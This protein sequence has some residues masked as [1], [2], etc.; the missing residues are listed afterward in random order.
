M[1]HDKSSCGLKRKDYV[2]TVEQLK[3]SALSALASRA[4]DKLH[5]I[6]KRV[7]WSLNF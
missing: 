3:S 4:L 5:L 2:F 6:V 7:I 1:G